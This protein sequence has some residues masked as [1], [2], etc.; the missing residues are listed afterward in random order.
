MRGCAARRGRFEP[1][2]RRGIVHA[3]KANHGP[4]PCA[5]KRFF[6]AGGQ[7]FHLQKAPLRQ[8]QHAAVGGRAASIGIHGK[9]QREAP[10]EKGRERSLRLAPGQGRPGGLASV[11]QGYAIP[12]RKLSLRHLRIDGM[13]P[14]F[15]I[16]AILGMAGSPVGKRY[17]CVGAAFTRAVARLQR[18]I[19]LWPRACQRDMKAQAC[20]RGKLP[21]GLKDQR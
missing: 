14:P 6:P 15:H 3:V 9:I 19:P 4:A 2:N 10:A 20:A 17:P 1:A 13:A 5:G 8:A 16:C 18:G 12:R 7:R 11:A 21:L